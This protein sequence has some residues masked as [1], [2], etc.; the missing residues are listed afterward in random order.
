MNK[1]LFDLVLS[2]DEK[3]DKVRT[4]L[5]FRKNGKSTTFDVLDLNKMQVAVDGMKYALGILARVY[6]GKLHENGLLSDEEYKNILDKS[7]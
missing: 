1:Q 6:V 2:F 7:N 3:D 4:S 5:S